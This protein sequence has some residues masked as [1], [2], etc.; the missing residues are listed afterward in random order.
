MCSPPRG[1]PRTGSHT[2]A[3]PYSSLNSACSRVW[4]QLSYCGTACT[5]VLG[6]S[7]H[8]LSSMAAPLQ[9]PPECRRDSAASADLVSHSA[10]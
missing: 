8:D 7:L 10:A 3:M 9:L 5:E 1:R 2:E 4:T 6:L